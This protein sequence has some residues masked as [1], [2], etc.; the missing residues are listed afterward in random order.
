MNT[1]SYNKFFH[2]KKILITGN[3]GFVGSYLSIILLLF[4]AKVLGFSLKKKNKGYLSNNKIYKRSIKTIYGN[5]LK[6]HHYKKKIK[7][8]NP[9]IIIHLASQPVVQESYKNTKET[10]LTNI[11]GTIELFELVKKMPS[12]NQVLIFTSDKVY[13][14]LKGK[15]L[16][17]DANLGGLDPYSSSKSSQD[18][19]A[20]SYKESFFKYSKNIIIVRAGNIIGGGDFEFSRLIPDL[21]LS[22]KKNKKFFLRNPNA[23]RPWQHIFDVLNALL[24][25]ISNSYKKLE[26]NSIIFNI[27]PSKNSNIKVINLVNKFKKNFDNFEFGI[28]NRSNFNE[29]KILRL[30]NEKIKKKF[31]WRPYISTSLALKLTAQW[32]EKFNHNP[33]NIYKFS[34]DQ[35]KKY[36]YLK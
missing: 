25:I 31:N 21:F 15:A 13:R 35:I 22:I 19:I 9:E 32:Y 8:F 28:K 10:Y 27:G 30:S 33:N 12:V 36:F 17:E 7:K 3:S 4:G 23:I 20:N 18:I 1:K 34:L 6:I 24:I 5:I 11:F 2:K 14:N 26:N 16:N 29:T